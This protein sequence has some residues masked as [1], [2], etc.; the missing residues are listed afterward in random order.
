MYYK[1]TIREVYIRHF[2]RELPMNVALKL[3][4]EALCG[5]FK[6]FD[7]DLNVLKWLC[8]KDYVY[9]IY[10]GHTLASYRINRFS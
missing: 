8:R 5:W 7:Y 9:S 6:Q 2:H 10:F 3:T 1:H 4:I